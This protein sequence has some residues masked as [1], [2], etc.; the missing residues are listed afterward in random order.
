[1]ESLPTVGGGANRAERQ[2][3]ILTAGTER[4]S[5]LALSRA[6]GRRQSMPSGSVA[7][8]YEA[9][10]DPRQ[11]SGIGVESGWQHEVGRDVEP[12]VVLANLLSRERERRPNSYC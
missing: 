1:M 2:E 9:D 8:K 7:G 6:A 5:R 12:A 11:P 4:P 3:L 10:D